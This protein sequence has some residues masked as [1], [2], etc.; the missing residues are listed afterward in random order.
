MKLRILKRD[1]IRL[2]NQLNMI[3][4]NT[5]VFA[6]MKPTDKGDLIN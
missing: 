2:I 6:R 3:L 1:N 4:I 5:N